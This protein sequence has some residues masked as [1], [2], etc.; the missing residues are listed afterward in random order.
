MTLNN[1]N[2]VIPGRDAHYVFRLYM[3]DNVDHVTL[4][5]FSHKSRGV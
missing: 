4:S 5:L 1:L 3:N 2:I